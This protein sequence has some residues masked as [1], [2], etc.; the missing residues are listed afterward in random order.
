MAV[1]LE[2]FCLMTFQM[3]CGRKKKAPSNFSI[4]CTAPILL[5]DEME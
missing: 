2:A 5:D 1:A 3:L 4:N